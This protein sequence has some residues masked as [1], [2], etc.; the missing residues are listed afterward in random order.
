[1]Y[2]VSDFFCFSLLRVLSPYKQLLGAE[3]WPV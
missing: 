2:N 3:L 1:M